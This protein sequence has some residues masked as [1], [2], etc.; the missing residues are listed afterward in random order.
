MKRLTKKQKAFADNYLQERGAK[1]TK[2]IINNYYPNDSITRKDLE[3]INSYLEKFK[4][5]IGVKKSQDVYFIR[6]I[7]TKRIKI[8][9][10]DSVLTRFYCLAIASPTKLKLEAVID[11]GGK[12][13]EDFLHKKYRK[14]H[15]KNEWFESNK[16]LEEFITFLKEYGND[17][18][19][20]SV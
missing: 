3:S 5:S 2:D 4:E 8:G 9:M 10:S 7:E 20:K 15:Y 1:E 17:K 13:L 12:E 14:F 19:K 16:E 6:C 18:T 11:F